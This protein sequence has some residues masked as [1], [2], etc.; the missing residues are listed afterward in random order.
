MQWQDCFTVHYKQWSRQGDNKT[1]TSYLL[2]SNDA[3]E[4]ASA[5]HAGFTVLSCPLYW[6]L[7]LSV[8]ELGKTNM[9]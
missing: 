9:C 3:S 7:N 8:S 1:L 6:R 5:M 4:R 2:T